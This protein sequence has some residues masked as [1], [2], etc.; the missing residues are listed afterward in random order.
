MTRRRVAL[1]MAVL[2]ALPACRGGS[3]S[4]RATPSSPS[5][6]LTTTSTTT[7][8]PTAGDLQRAVDAATAG[9]HVTVHLAVIDLTSGVRAG[10]LD[11]TAVLS[12]SLYKLFVARE[13]FRRVAA[14]SLKRTDPSGDG[15]HDVAECL[16][17]MIVISDDRC[18]VAGLNMI[19]RGGFDASLHGDGFADTSMATPQKTSAADVAEL[20]RR[21]H[22]G[23]TELYGLLR[24]QQVNDRIPRGLPPGTPLAHKTGDRTG[25][26]HDAGVMTTPKG[27]VV[28]AVLTGPWPKPCCHEEHIGAPERSAF[29]VIGQVAHSV[30]VAVTSPGTV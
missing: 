2:T 5:A 18:G 3:P 22:D 29:A 1:L 25:W 7:A 4:R 17:L 8:A 15:R 20:L 6:A 27:D 16:R 14:G 24:Q 28:L 13:L 30:Y 21:E 11:R 26:A 12:A 19:G 10:H 9:R 23:N